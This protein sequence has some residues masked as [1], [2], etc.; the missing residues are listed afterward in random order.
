M[1]KSDRFKPLKIIKEEKNQ[2]IEQ[3]SEEV[4]DYKFIKSNTKD[5]KNLFN[6]N[7]K[8]KPKFNF[9]FIQKYQK[10]DKYQKSKTLTLN[11]IKRLKRSK[12]NL[13][14]MN[15]LSGFYLFTALNLYFN[16]FLY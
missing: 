16:S 12:T 6:K 3:P 4:K 7:V 10:H 8:E 1:K 11:P 15:I 13:N 9:H 14:T 5:L 2:E